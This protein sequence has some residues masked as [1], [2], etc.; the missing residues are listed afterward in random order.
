MITRIVRIDDCAEVIPGFSF[1][2]ALKDDPNGTHQVVMGKHIGD[3]DKYEYK[4]ED[5]FRL[6]PERAVDE[7]Y[8]IRPGDILFMSKGAKNQAV[9]VRSVPEPTI[10]PSSFFII[11]V[12]RIVPV[13]SGYLL[14]SINQQAV[15]NRVNELRT[16]AGT[17]M[18]PRKGF[19]AIEIPLPDLATQQTIANLCSLQDREAGL[20]RDLAEKSEKLRR[21]VGQ[22]ILD[23]ISTQKRENA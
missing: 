10:A 15:R 23:S 21:V 13:D 8:L 5:R 12:G 1:T 6:A 20:I 16:G 3:G 22:R 2:G 14:W 11:R 17:P 9:M 19:C 7:K 18:I 4:D